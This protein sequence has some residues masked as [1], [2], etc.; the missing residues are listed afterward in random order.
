MCEALAPA[1]QSKLWTFL[2][3]C[4]SGSAHVMFPWVLDWAA[5][6]LWAVLKFMAPLSQ[7]RKAQQQNKWKERQGVL[8]TW[9]QTFEK[10]AHIYFVAGR[11]LLY[12]LVKCWV[13]CLSP[14]SKPFPF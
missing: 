12:N 1:K 5:E 11:Y 8:V 10:P 2:L 3:H 7:Q 13:Y 14:S 6:S 9:S 4:V